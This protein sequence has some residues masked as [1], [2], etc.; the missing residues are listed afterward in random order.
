MLTGTGNVGVVHDTVQAWYARKTGGDPESTF[1]FT[2]PVV[3]ETFDGRLNDTFGQHVTAEHVLRRSTPHEE[4]RSR[5][6]RGGGTGMVAYGF[7]AGIG[8]ASRRVEMGGH[9]YMLGRT[10]AGELRRAGPTAIAG[11][12]VGRSC[13][14]RPQATVSSPTKKEGSIIVV[15]ATDAPLMPNQLRRLALRATHGVARVGGIP[16]RRPAICSGIFNG[17]AGK[18]R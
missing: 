9:A 17:A 10:R 3:A 13:L 4:G 18:S 5:K 6:E 16:E 7:K 15:I 14:R 11:V 8:T 2:L 12:P 1:L